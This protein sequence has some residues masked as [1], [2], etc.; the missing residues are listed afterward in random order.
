[1][2][3]EL[4]VVP[5]VAVIATGGR[6]TASCAVVATAVLVA[7]AGLVLVGVIQNDELRR[8]A[9][10]AA[11]LVAVSLREVE[12]EVELGECGEMCGRARR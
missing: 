2:A 6:S 8:G 4:R 11:A 10:T 12:G 7:R 5:A 3:V 1:M 9:M